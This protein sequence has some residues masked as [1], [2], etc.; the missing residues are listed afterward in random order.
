MQDIEPYFKWRDSYVSEEDKLSPFFGRTYS[1]FEYSA[2]IY[3]YY[4]H[5]QWDEFGSPTLYMKLLFINYKNKYAI[6]ELLGEWNDCITNDIM[7]FKRDVIDILI[8]NGISKFVLMCDNVLNFHG[9]DD[10]YYEEWLDDIKDR[11]GWVCLVNT[12]DHVI[13]ELKRTKLQ[14]YINFGPQYNEI[15]WHRKTPENAFLEIQNKIERR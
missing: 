5:P 8:K 3:N 12:F 7:F 10:C 9:S 11:G 15:D 6:I 14:Y 2:K 4:I 1:E 13:Q